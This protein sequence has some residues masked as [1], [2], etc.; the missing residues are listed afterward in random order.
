[1]LQL[2]TQHSGDVI[3]ILCKGRIVLG[4]DLH[5]LK[6]ATLSQNTPDVVLDLSSVNLIDA[7]GLGALVDLHQ[8]FQCAGKKMELMDPTGFVSQVFRIVRLDTVFHIVR[9]RQ[10][11]AGPASRRKPWSVFVQLCI[12]TLVAVGVVVPRSGSLLGGSE[13]RQ[14]SY[15]LGIPASRSTQR[16]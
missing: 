13:A 12:T 7:A 9:T 2:A 16:V 1:M 10:I 8:R 4:G 5:R 3:T 15:S 14:G 6:V 11:A